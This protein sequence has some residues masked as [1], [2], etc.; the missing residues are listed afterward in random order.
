M[1]IWTI[2]WYEV[3]RMLRMRYILLIQFF[4]PLLIIFI[5]GSALSTAFKTE[6]RALKPVKVDVVQADTGLLSAGFNEFIAAAEVKN[7]LQTV[8][9]QTRDEAVKRIKDGTSDFALIIPSDF[10]SRVLGGSEASWEMILGKDYGQN[11]VAQ[12]VLRSFLDQANLN[13][14]AFIAAGPAAAEAIQKQGG[15]ALQKPTDT[16]PVRIGKLTTANGSY[17]AIQYYA[18]SMLVMFLLYSGMSAA[19][20]LQSEKEKHTLSRLN[21]MPI[22]EYDIL[23]GKVIGN[24]F[25]SLLQAG[26]IIAATSF[27]YGAD[28]GHSWVMLFLICLSI[29]TA[30]MSLAILVMIVAKSMK[31]IGTIF[32]MLIIAMTF[33]SGG[34]TPLPEG[35]MQ[36]IGEFTLNYWGMQSMFRIMLGS[37]FTLILHHM[38]IL[39]GIGVGMLLV[40][41]VVYRK[42]GYHE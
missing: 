23:L 21:A 32:Q 37:E 1:A 5:L 12:M 39:A 6:D 3:L 9:I 40:S 19:I 4:M 15:V 13:Q 11:L 2:A 18:A 16:S 7:R 38:L 10:S 17:T 33:L 25:I 28:W 8:M 34:F 30:S 29:I 27:F 24:A 14:A 42:V 35:L 31:T 36:R 20:G 26:T 41:L 22:H